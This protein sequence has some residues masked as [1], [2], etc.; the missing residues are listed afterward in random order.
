VILSSCYAVITDHIHSDAG[1]FVAA[2][3]YLTRVTSSYADRQWGLIETSLLKIHAQCLKKLNRRDDYARMLLS[4]L[5]KTA[6]QQKSHLELKLR[7]RFTAKDPWQ[8]DDQIETRG[9]LAELVAYSEEL[10][11]DLSVPIVRYFT[12]ITVEPF[13][14]HFDHKDGFSIKLKMR[15]LLDDA[16]QIDQTRVR[17]TTISDGAS[18]DIW[19]ESGESMEII[20]GLNNIRVGANVSVNLTLSASSN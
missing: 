15:H 18:R 14:R 20:P 4:M 13:I 3:N 7:Q 11:Y 1:D 6:A 12:D 19:L 9:L 2:A 16:L 17:L 8:D 5:A 10:P